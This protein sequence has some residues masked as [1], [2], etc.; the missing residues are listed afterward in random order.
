MAYARL[1]DLKSYLGVDDDTTADDVLLDSLLTRASANI[2]THCGRWFEARTDTRYFE[3]DSRDGHTLI[4]DADLI[5]ITTLNN[6]DDDGTEIPDTEYWLV[7]RNSGPPY[8]GIRL[9]SASTYTWEFDQDGW[10]SVAGSW[11]WTAEPPNDIVQAC[12]RW[13]AYLYHQKDAPVYETTA[14]PESGVITTPVGIPVDV[15]LM[16]APYVRRAG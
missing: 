3:D 11:G 7:D 8:Y 6:G 2:D 15:K 4:M 13:A 1:Y 10:V 5:S 14:F 12:I 9:Q 16:L